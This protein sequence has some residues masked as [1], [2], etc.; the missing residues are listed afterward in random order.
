MYHFLYSVY[1]ALRRVI[2]RRAERPDWRS[3]AA[4]KL[5]GRIES[6]YNVFL[7]RYW[8]KHPRTAY[9]V[10]R[11]KR[12]QKLIVSLTSFPARIDTVWLTIESLFQQTLKADDIILWLAEDQFESKESLPQT[13]LDAEKRGLTIR[14]C[15]DLRSH[16]KYFYAMQEYPEELIVLAD[17]DA[18]YPRDMLAKLFSL[19][20]KYPKDIISSTSAVT[21]TGYHSVPSQWHAPKMEQVLL[22]SYIA[23]PFTGSGTLYPPKSLDSRVFQKELICLLCPFADDLWL[24]F[25][26]LGAHT[27]VTVFHPYRDI[28]MMID[29]T[30]ASSLWQINGRD[31]QNDVQWRAILDHFGDK[32]LPGEIL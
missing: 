2:R 25:M 19:H 5:I 13:L 20:E 14:F 12:K 18:F 3:R 16:K 10:T 15:D 22:H 31:M 11:E 6:Y 28:P 17:D 21:T 23:Q 27:P 29:G 7:R 1:F 9:G 4:Q 24:F 26:A 8:E 32:A 30:S